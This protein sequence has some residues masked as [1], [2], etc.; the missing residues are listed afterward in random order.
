MTR[1]LMAILAAG[2][3]ALTAGCNENRETGAVT[4]RS[5]GETTRAPGAEAVEERD[6]ALIR[7]VNAIPGQA[8]V[9]IYAGDSAAFRDVGYRSAT[10]YQEIPDNLFNFQ[11]KPGGP[12]TEAAAQNREN[13]QDG[14]H[15]TVVA[16]PS[17]DPNDQNLR[18]LDDDLKPVTDGKARVRF[19]NGLAGDTD[20]DLYVRSH[21]D[22][23]FDGV[24]FKTEAGWKEVDP[25]SG[26]LV[27]RPDNK[28]TTLASLAN[29]NLEPGKS[30]T[31]VLVGRAGKYDLMKI[32]DEVGR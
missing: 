13:L 26:T 7:A 23:I 6:H 19:I 32:E 12:G 24:N 25:V 16:L 14:G 4:S 22:P 30:Y 11:L 5:G 28:Q 2:A 3:V 1:S 18:V 29:T 31:F 20:V 27:A 21:K 17:E 8:A 9:T 10:G 15:Y